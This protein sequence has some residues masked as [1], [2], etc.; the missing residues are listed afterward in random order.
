VTGGAFRSRQARGVLLAGA[1]VLVALGIALVLI[2]ATASNKPSLRFA[3]P[4]TLTALGHA[5]QQ[6][7]LA[8]AAGKPVIINF[9]AS[10]CGP[11]KKETPLLAS[12]YRQHDGRV[13]IIGIDSADQQAAALKFI[14]ADHVDYPVGFDP[15]PASTAIAYGALQLPQTFFLNAKHQIVRHIRGDLTRSE[16]ESWASSLGSS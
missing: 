8:S 7:S 16:L 6:V 12:F 2:S 14:D 1:A 9:F 3:K 5:G 11:C 4:F 15:I 10:W 13:L